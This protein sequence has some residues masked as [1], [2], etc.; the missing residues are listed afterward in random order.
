MAGLAAAGLAAAFLTP[1]PAHASV[2]GH[3]AGWRVRL[4]GE[5]DLAKG[6]TVGDTVVG[7]LSGIDYD[8][9][10]GRYYLIADDTTTGPARFY[11]ARIGLRRD[12]VTGVRFTGVRELLRP[13]GSPFP[14]ANDEGRQ[15]VDPESI[16]VDPR[17]GTL[18]WSSEGE[19]DVPADGSAPYLVDPFVRQAT[20]HGHYLRGLRLPANLRMSAR[21]TGPRANLVLE[22]LT[23]STDGRRV[24]ASTE[25][26]LYQDGPIATVDHGAT[27]RITWWDRRSGRP[28]RQLAYRLDAIPA[29]PDPPTASADNG[30]S[31]LLAV[32]RHHYLA[33]ERSFAAGVGNSIRVYEFGTRGATNVLHRRSLAGGGYRAVRKHLLVDLGTLGLPHVDNIEGVT[34]GPRLPG[35][36]RTLVFVADDNFNP[37]Q[38]GQIIAVALHR[39]RR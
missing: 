39:T 25:G 8:R 1:V 29:K 26:A 33:V 16:R 34:W 9:R 17:D 32:D 23:L 7:E 10:T 14:R 38:T 19:R 35:G 36:D 3:D 15:S 12:A 30:I 31:E 24:A 4:V 37:S 2:A 28:V 22:G 21:R 27:N 18:W 6:V 13:D 20:R 11:T 5:R